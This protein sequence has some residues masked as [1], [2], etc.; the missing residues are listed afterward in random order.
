MQLLISALGVMMLSAMVATC[1]SSE[2]QQGNAIK[3]DHEQIG[4]I[5][6]RALL[7][8]TPMEA[9]HAALDTVRAFPSVDSAWIT[10]SSFFVR[11][12]H[13]GVV[14]WTISPRQQPK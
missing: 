7:S 9:F 4:A 13:G 3:R 8:E 10:S 11:Y 5:L 14:S 1:G 2:S 6:D 12:K